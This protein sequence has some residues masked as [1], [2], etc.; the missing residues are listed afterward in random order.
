MRGPPT[1]VRLVKIV[2]FVGSILS[3][4]YAY[5][6]GLFPELAG[7]G[8]SPKFGEDVVHAIK[9]LGCGL[10]AGLVAWEG[11]CA[12]TKRPLPR[13]QVRVALYLFAA[14]G[15]YGY[16]NMGEIGY[17]RVYHRWDIFH[18]YMGSKYHSEIGYK[19]IYAA[20][21]V[22]QSELSPEMMEETKKRR[23]RNLETDTVVPATEAL[24]KAD[25]IKAPFSPERWERY[26]ADVS[27]F[28]SQC[29]A[30]WWGDMQTDHGYNPAPLW[31]TVGKGV[32]SLGSASDGFLRFLSALDFFLF[33]VMFGAIAWAFGGPIACLTAL[34]WGVQWPGNFYFTWGAFLRHDWICALVMAACLARKRMYVASGFALAYSALVRVFP[35]A[36]IGGVVLY[37]AHRYW[38]TRTWSRPHVRTVLGFAAGCVILFAISVAGAGTKAYPEFVHHVGQLSSAAVTNHMGLKNIATFDYNERVERT[39]DGRA[40]DPFE[41]W[42]N[43]KAKRAER[44]RPLILA[45]MAAAMG[46]YAYAVIKSRLSRHVWVIYAL[47]TLVLVSA[48]E[49]MNYYYSFFL[50]VPLLGIFGRKY[51]V[52]ALTCASLSAAVLVWPKTASHFD[53]RCYFESIIFVAF[54]AIATYWVALEQPRVRSQAAA[55]NP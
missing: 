52:L 47:G 38:T 21:A 5:I 33:A 8:T 27:W 4:V 14:A 19:G 7:Q 32:A 48:T 28:R 24:A 34:Y 26:K 53:V 12:V 20:T 15:A 30:A 2:A 25:A 40:R 17:P 55:G 51:T 3:L 42:K 1:A 43:R 44:R 50:L 36:L 37:A 10:C 41:N 29:D 35:G 31:T 46:L 11:Y 13:R 54:A 22:A 9:T 39:H 49:L 23:I 6:Y 16:I 18:Y 45:A